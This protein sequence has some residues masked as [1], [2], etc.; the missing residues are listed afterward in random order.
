MDLNESQRRDLA[1]RIERERVRQFKGNR[2]KAYSAAG[3]NST[4]W[5]KAE[6]PNEPLAERTIIAIVSTLWPETG[7]DWRLIDPPLKD[8]GEPLLTPEVLAELEKLS[9]G[10]REQIRAVLEEDERRRQ[11]ERERGAS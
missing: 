8:G 4:T 9:P 7:G 6:S 11:A 10:P 1:A 3:V 2:R 5:T